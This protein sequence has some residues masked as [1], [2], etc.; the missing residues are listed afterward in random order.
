VG[1]TSNRVQGDG[2]ASTNRDGAASTMSLAGHEAIATSLAVTMRSTVWNG[3]T[4]GSA[5][6]SISQ[7]AS[8]RCRILEWAV[9]GRIDGAAAWYTKVR[10]SPTAP[11]QSDK[12]R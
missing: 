8:T 5:M 2:R 9:G 11:R 6:A 7:M 1:T 10:A 4:T 3:A 12:T